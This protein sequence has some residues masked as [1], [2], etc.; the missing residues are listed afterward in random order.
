MSEN[1]RVR[2]KRIFLPHKKCIIHYVRNLLHTYV[3]SAMYFSVG[4][5]REL[6]CSL[7][8]VFLGY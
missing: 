5:Y 8:H 3:R 2:V 1:Y 7:S 6:L 4:K